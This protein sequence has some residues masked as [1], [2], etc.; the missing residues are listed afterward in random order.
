MANEAIA[1]IK[2]DQNTLDYFDKYDKKLEQIEK[3]SKATATAIAAAF[4]GLRDGTSP[5][6][7]VLTQI[8]D[9]MEAIGKT[10]AGINTAAQAVGSIGQQANN[11]ATGVQTANTSL[12]QTA[13]LL[14]QIGAGKYNTSIVS[15]ALTDTTPLQEKL[16]SLKETSKQSETAL[17]SFVEAQKKT[18]NSNVFKNVDASNI[19]KFIAKY[20]E[21]KAVQETLS[22]NPLIFS[23]SNVAT[24]M[25][26][27]ITEAERL[28]KS[29]M[30]AKLEVDNMVRSL[31]FQ[32]SANS[33]V[34]AMTERA[35][36]LREGIIECEKEFQKLKT[37]GNLYGADGG[38]SSS[39]K[40]YA[41]KRKD[42][43][44]ELRLISQTSTEALKADERKAASAEKAAER[45]KKAWLQ[46]LSAEMKSRRAL[47]R[48][49]AQTPKYANQYHEQKQSSLTSTFSK[50][51][52]TA[53]MALAE[54][55]AARTH[56]EEA[57][58]VELLKQAR[59]NL[60][61]TDSQ[62]KTKLDA[63]NAAIEKHNKSLQE[64]GIQS[65]NLKQKH[66]NLMDIGGQLARQ[67]AL[68]FSVSQIEG[69]VNKIAKVRGEFELQ[70]RSLEAILQNKTQAD[71]I[72]QKTVDLAIK[73]PFQIKE[74]V[75]YTKQ[76]AAYRIEG[77]K[78]YDTTKRLADVS[79][80]LG[81][82]MQRLILAYGQVKA[83]AY[84]RGCLGYDTDIIMYDGSKKK[85]QDVAVGDLLRGDDDKPR[86]VKE[87]IRGEE[88]MYTVSGD[89]YS[90]RVNQNH[91]LT[92]YN[93]HLQSIDDVYV[94][95]VLDF[96][97][98]DEGEFLSS[99]M[100]VRFKDGKYYTYPI[101][102]KKSRKRK[103]KYYGFVIDQN[104]RFL[105][106][107][108]VVTHNTE[109][110]QFTEAGVNMYGELQSYFQ[111]VKGEAYTTAQIV[112]M[113]SKRKVTFEDVEAVFQRLTSQGGLFYNMQEI[114]SETLN[115][116]I[117]NLKDSFDVLMN[118]IGK[119]PFNEW[120]LKGTVDMVRIL[121]EH[122]QLVA[123]IMLPFAGILLG[124][125]SK[126]TAAKVAA[127]S[128][129]AEWKKNI[130]YI[131]SAHG[132]FGKMAATM[133]AFKWSLSG[134]GFLFAVEILTTII[135]KIME[136]NEAAIAFNK[137]VAE[138]RVKIDT[139]GYDF[140]NAKADDNQSV[141]EKQKT[142]LKKLQDEAAR[143]NIHIA[144][145]LDDVTE[146]NIS[147][148]F[149]KA[150]RQVQQLQD[151]IA[152]SARMDKKNGNSDDDYKDF[153]EYSDAVI[154][155][156]AN[157]DAALN[158]MLYSTQKEIEAQEEV[159]ANSKNMSEIEKTRQENILKGL[160]ERA[161]KLFEIQKIET[162]G[163]NDFYNYLLKAQKLAD[164]A[165]PLGIA[166]G[167][168]SGR[169]VRQARKFTAP[170]ET[171]VNVYKRYLEDVINGAN[172]A[173]EAIGE[174]KDGWIKDFEDVKAAHGDWFRDLKSDDKKTREAAEYM[175]RNWAE[176][177]ASGETWTEA[178][179]VAFFK[180]FE[181][182]DGVAGTGFKVRLDTS[183]TDTQLDSLNKHLKNYFDN[184]QY[185]V[186]VGFSYED[187]GNKDI[188]EDIQSRAKAFWDA[189]EN[190]K[191]LAD[192]L[193]R[194]KMYKGGK[195]NRNDL[196]L[197][198][199]EWQKMFG[200]L[201]LTQVDTETAIKKLRE[202]ERINRR[203][204]TVDLGYQDPKQAKENAAA[205]AKAER[206]IWNERI[207]VLKEM[208]Q[209]YE[210]V[211]EHYGE[212]TAK[213]MTLSEYMDDLKYV[214]IGKVIKPEEIV[215]TKQGLVAAL[216]KVLAAMPSTLKDYFKKS[217]ELKK[218]ISEL[219]LQIKT[220]AAEK[221]LEE[222]KKKVEGI[223]TEFDLYSKLKEAGLHSFDIQ[224]MFP[225]ITM[226]FKQMRRQ[227][228]EQYAVL[229][230]KGEYLQKGTKEYEAYQEAV[231]NIA[232]KQL[233]YSRNQLQQLIKDYKT[234]LSERLQL[235]TWY[236]E[237]RTKI[238]E[239]AELQKNPALQGQFQRNLD[240]QYGQKSDE[241]RW[242]EF[243]QSDQYIDLFENLDYMSTSALKEMRA[244]LEEL[245]GSLHNLPADQ[246][247]AI[248]RQMDELDEKIMSRNPFKSLLESLR[249]YREALGNL[250]DVNPDGTLSD[251]KI[252]YG[253]LLSKYRT[254]QDIEDGAKEN[255][256]V[257]QN[258]LNEQ[259]ARYDKAV[260][261]GASKYELE[262]MEMKLNTQQAITEAAA[263]EALLQGK[264][265]QEYYDQIKNVNKTKN[266]KKE[267]AAEAA[268]KVANG[269]GTLASAIPQMA[270]D[271][272]SVFGEMSPWMSDFVEGLSDF[273]KG[274]Q[275]ISQG[276]QSIITGDVFSGVVNVI[277]GIVHQIG[278]AFRVGDR[279]LEREIQ[280]LQE[281]VENLQD[282]YDD[283]KE[284][285][286]SAWDM[287]NLKEYHKATLDN[288]DEQIA[289]YKSMIA[290]EKS[291]KKSDKDKIK[292]YED[293][294][295]EAEK[296]RQ[297]RQ[298][299][300]TEQLG[301]FG[302]ESNYQSAAQ[303][304]ADAWV[305]A[306]NEG[307][308][309]LDALNDT[310][311]DYIT[312]LIK[313][314]IML[315]A[316]K[317]Y[318]QPILDSIDN[319]LTKDSEDGEN[320]SESE[321]AKINAL[322]EA[323]LKAYDEYVSSLVD[324]LGLLPSNVD[325]NLDALQQGIEGISEQTAEALESLLNSIRF[326]LAT[327]QGDVAAIRTL[328]ESRY[329]GLATL[330]N[331]QSAV[332]ADETSESSASNPML[333]ELK[334]QT[335]YLKK[336]SDNFDG[337]FTS[338]QSSKGKGLRVY[339]Q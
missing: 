75:S 173:Q 235:D 5:L 264:I 181:S 204:A 286:D 312:N 142:Q 71:A 122:W 2:I 226:G 298:E 13:Q 97:R 25:G 239:N 10:G 210:K 335:G 245:R 225:G 102:I 77:D 108:N 295:E 26:V 209:Q 302:S 325:D 243:Q 323:N 337:A 3:H 76:L 172:D 74:L 237:E 51:N 49:A 156:S 127:S 73:S 41:T 201:V 288:I 313:K 53:S 136:A 48:A 100:G 211:R 104:K 250:R 303:A 318:I 177:F 62:Y 310:F 306:F 29:F 116:K 246:V 296:T 301:G 188:G 19:D 88:Q 65:E 140:E 307:E 186:K 249:E 270:E 171:D 187:L 174:F 119:D 82:D 46:E 60:D 253:T 254:Q 163:A 202:Y 336:L 86:I 263:Q 141:F 85:V 24:K 230:P 128:F 67:L 151:A 228:D 160:Q 89:G 84:L 339:V 99:Y 69:Y 197:S 61:K 178:G 257:Q 103:G 4:N 135:S 115:G 124:I 166:Q 22:K 123:N 28:K 31:E 152:F 147:D 205:A 252:S 274:G 221:K 240:T 331:T 290:L 322:K 57:A 93:T 192:Q 129:G 90:Y 138:N 50:K 54:S 294:L 30:S 112:D 314:Q 120:A 227:I 87:L 6:L 167:D 175:V 164:V 304:F 11:A 271:L 101:K 35:K 32:L 299:S 244:K 277:G 56:R 80:G 320:L 176:G 217:S 317:K 161:N 70:Q 134:V 58:A 283:L 193:E 278:A 158:T 316:S 248:V 111:E 198:A 182:W 43:E 259:Q 260:E 55:K 272:E 23:S 273:M 191:K 308:D 17:M 285:M 292:E 333:T 169:K 266:E 224:Q 81:V 247:K 220:E 183:D 92:L 110:R 165:A 315:R 40:Y 16:A 59:L 289:S 214:K 96:C 153:Q 148:V 241:L 94:L 206:D 130:R 258:A 145:E 159:L 126:T 261:D 79:A 222:V 39:A 14:N 179:R 275:Q 223:F 44:D 157:M 284:A 184:Q 300:Y 113:I 242:K 72:F 207:S 139:I 109:V 327:Q 91:I 189:A 329:G 311:D 144:T 200:S 321:L 21:L 133:K 232:K 68:L 63:I 105:I 293:A 34:T 114:Q 234:N 255:A 106:G 9:K 291:K 195:V 251:R 107:D 162:N 233:D 170:D 45:A 265:T 256:R 297:E 83:A 324:S 208:Q 269:F 334:A 203:A 33:G 78:L 282:A 95:D 330:A 18:L 190:A 154:T 66:R 180:F 236:F 268:G 215:P 332:Q 125:V 137:T 238:Q 309:A 196:K 319:A 194:S 8:R 231:K 287:T 279:K 276:V 229:F 218:N 27:T 146:E 118:D 212:D 326:F 15:L 7:A 36:K 168:I 280:S 281:N 213:A 1:V 328:L 37:A 12:T 267:T 131:K 47:E 155:S 150:Q 64:A 52:T 262:V 219:K 132:A 199:E 216:E 121:A 98:Y 305:D 20:K 42:Y 185:I 143:Q 38:L 338:S 117:A 149:R